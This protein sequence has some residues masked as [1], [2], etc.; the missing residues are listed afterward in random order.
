MDLPASAK[1]DAPLL[2]E[3]GCCCSLKHSVLGRS[4]TDCS[5]VSKDVLVSV[6]NALKYLPQELSQVDCKSAEIANEDAS[7]QQ[8]VHPSSTAGVSKLSVRGPH[9]I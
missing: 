4:T 3:C 2:S 5:E 8:L 6:V 9:H 1:R 7:K